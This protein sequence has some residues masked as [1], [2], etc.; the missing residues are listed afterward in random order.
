MG[1]K[2]LGQCG[3]RGATRIAIRR[4]EAREHLLF[5]QIFALS[6]RIELEAHAA[7]DFV[8]QPAECAPPGVGRLFEDPLFR[9]GQQMSAITAHRSEKV[10]P[11]GQRW[12]AEQRVGGVGFDRDPLEFEKQQLVLDLADALLNTLHQ[13]S[14]ARIAGV[15]SKQ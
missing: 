9:F 2:T 3:G 10:P 14:V 13:R 1:A 11:L 15:G 4:I 12:I 7:H 6:V 5:A 8:E